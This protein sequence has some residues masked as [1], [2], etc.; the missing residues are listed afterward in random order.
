MEK[1]Y[2]NELAFVGIRFCQVNRG[3]LK[4]YILAYICGYFRNATIC[5]IPKRTKSRKSFSMLAETVIT[6]PKLT[7]TAYTST[8]S[9]TKLSEFRSGFFFKYLWPK[10][11]SVI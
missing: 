1:S 6:E 4:K 10:L 9:C 11:N 5:C 2:E 8:K 7:A 3:V